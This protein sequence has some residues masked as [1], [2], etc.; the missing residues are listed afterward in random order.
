MQ[1]AQTSTLHAAC[2]RRCAA[3]LAEEGADAP[4]A[5]PNCKGPL[6]SLGSPHATRVDAASPDGNDVVGG[7]GDWGVVEDP[8]AAAVGGPTC[9]G[10]AAASVGAEPL[11]FGSP[12]R[13]AQS[14]SC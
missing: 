2:E 14:S 4:P 9:N 3:P 11:P 8:V 6:P 5:G 10:A 13:D 7:H 1:R 12:D